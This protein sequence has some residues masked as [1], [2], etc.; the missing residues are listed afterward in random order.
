MNRLMFAQKAFIVKN[1]KLLLVK[2]G[3]NDPFHP[4]EWEVPGGRL[5][6]GESLDEH[7]RREVFEEVGLNVLPGHPFSMWSW[8]M[9]L[10]EDR[11]QAVAIGRLCKALD[12]EISTSH[13]VEGDFLSSV[14]WVPVEELLQFDFIDEM[15]P[16][17]EAFVELYR[18]G[19]IQ[20]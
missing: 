19:V 3:D 11:V 9:P 16:T 7:I 14:C 20:E 15:I 6:F 8:F 4:N 1:G 12:T 18:Q 13:R 10:G 5:E 2:K 17:I